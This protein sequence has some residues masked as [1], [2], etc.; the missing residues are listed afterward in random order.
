LSAIDLIQRQLEHSAATGAGSSA[1]PWRKA[2]SL[3]SDQSPAAPRTAELSENEKREL[4]AYGFDRYFNTAALFGTRESC[5]G[6]LNRLAEIGV[7]EIACLID[8]GVDVESAL[9]SL[10]HLSALKDLHG[11]EILSSEKIHRDVEQLDLDY[12]V[13]QLR[14]TVSVAPNSV[15]SE[16][17]N[18]ADYLASQVFTVR[19]E[20]SARLDQ[21]R[22]REGVTMFVLLL[23][24][25]QAL[26][27]R[28]G[29]RDDISVG[30]CLSLA[31]PAQAGDGE[32]VNTLV[33]RATITDDIGFGD[34][35][36]QARSTAAEALDHHNLPFRKLR[37][38]LAA[39]ETNQLFSHAFLFLQDAP[40]TVADP[41]W[42]VDILKKNIGGNEYQS[43]LAIWPDGQKLQGVFCG[44]A[45][46]YEA[47]LMNQMPAH[48]QS[49]LE[50]VA[51]ESPRPVSE[52]A[53]ISGEESVRLSN[54]FNAAL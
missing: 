50:D 17:L 28:Y 15:L 13:Y 40:L 22:E 30:T 10:R 46:E 25:F 33:L 11:Q 9:G 20:L 43:V 23:T 12:W 31:S 36:R 1:N 24:A 6:L 39:N 54:D 49:L 53:I 26:L 34:L 41:A 32:T 18:S 44:N 21:L 37:E 16:A 51:A 48:F 29:S 2:A 27:R 38:S 42:F 52:L 47:E 5:L 14:D 7:D 3:R 19:A 4:A 45:R 35:L 8:F